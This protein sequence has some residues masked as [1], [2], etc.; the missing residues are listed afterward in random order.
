MCVCVQS[1]EQVKTK[2]ELVFYTLS[3]A[4]SFV[5]C[6]F[7]GGRIQ[8][9]LTKIVVRRSREKSRRFK[10]F[11]GMDT[12]IDCALGFHSFRTLFFHFLFCCRFKAS[13]SIFCDVNSV[14]KYHR[15]DH[16]FFRISQYDNFWTSYV[17]CVCN[18]IQNHSITVVLRPGGRFL[19]RHCME[20]IL[21]V[22]L[23]RWNSLKRKVK[24]CYFGCFADATQVENK[25]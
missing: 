23:R 13:D 6:E 3:C 7:S 9:T 2:T 17:M 1:L 14:P 12:K 15:I 5:F 10:K 21:H 22:P 16:Q 25:C 20:P 19:I 24:I 11:C 18:V 8:F 4:E